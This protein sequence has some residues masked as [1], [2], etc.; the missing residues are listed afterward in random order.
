MRGRGLGGVGAGFGREMGVAGRGEGG[1]GGARAGRAGLE[2]E[3]LTDLSGSYWGTE[4][5]ALVWT[6]EC[7]KLDAKH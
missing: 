6:G 7:P 1:G 5:G 4:L 2:S 3:T